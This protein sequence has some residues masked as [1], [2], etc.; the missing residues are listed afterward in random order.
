MS[1]RE[2]LITIL[3]GAL[4][5]L[6]EWLPVSS[7]GNL[8]IFL[9]L[10]GESPEV[11]VQLSLFLQLG[12]TLSA[13]IYYRDDIGRAVADAPGWRPR[14][15]F[16]GD[17]AETTFVVVATAMTGLVGIPIYVLLMDVAGELTG[18]AFVAVI[19][20]L[21]V[22]TG[23]LQQTSSAVGLGDRELPTLF[24]A[25]L[26]GALQGFSI[27]PGVSRSGTTTSGL[28]FRGYDGPSA[29]R[30]S[31]LLSIPAGIGAGVLTA[32]DAGGLP[33]VGPTAAAGA[34][35][36]SVVVGYAAIDALLRIVE[37]VPFWAICYG[38]GGLA[39]VGGGLVTAL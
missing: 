19:G 12:T 22:I 14:E 6:L 10:A 26:V 21:L 24:D 39:I 33:A 1:W 13:A 23:L 36:A 31:F 34:L 35:L 4:Q 8:S 29:F 7:Q 30:L 5:G 18:G 11:A 32:V 38:L 2:L 37:R 20:V 17:N 25:V 27:L 15:A 3:A 9:S 16:E 28:L